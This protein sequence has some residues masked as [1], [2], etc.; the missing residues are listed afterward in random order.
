MPVFC[1]THC[2]TELSKS[3]AKLSLHDEVSEEDAVAG[4][5][6]YETNV[7]AMTGFA[8]LGPITTMNWQHFFDLKESFFEEVKTI[9]FY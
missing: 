3:H 1:L 7:A 9:C 2:R 8:P 5:R 6:I 4:C